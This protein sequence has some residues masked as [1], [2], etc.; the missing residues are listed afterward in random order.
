MGNV[1]RDSYFYGTQNAASQSYGVESF[2]GSDNLVENNIFQH[3]TAPMMANGP[4][5]GTVFGYN[6]AIDDYYDNGAPQWMQGSSYVHAADASLILNEG[7]EGPGFFTDAVHGSHDFDTAFRNYFT[8]YEP[9][10]TNQT[11]AILINAFGR[12]MNIVGNVLG[13][14]GYHSQYEWQIGMTTGYDT[15]I[16][17]IGSGLGNCPDDT[18]VTKTLLRWGNYDVVSGST[19]WTASEVPS[20]L[21]QYANPVPSSTALPASLYLQ[22]KPSWWPRSIPWPPIGP[23]VS[24]GNEPGLAGHVNMIPA[25]VCYKNSPLDGA[26]P[27][28]DVGNRTLLFNANSC[29]YN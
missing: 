17:N 28:D 15:A 25:H 5:A 2:V 13:T 19:H 4:S 14:Q 20:E 21:N 29:Y 9:N 7:N 12:Y 27:I 22:S 23:D 11:N 18:L 3:I 1:I 24:G 8:G 16:F 10:K 26:Y 6:Y